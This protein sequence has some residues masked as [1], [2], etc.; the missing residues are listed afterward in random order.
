[1]LTLSH[2]YPLKTREA[3]RSH[4]YPPP[5]MTRSD[6][7]TLSHAYPLKTREA[8]RS[9]MYPPP[10][11]THMYPPPH[12]TRSDMLTL[13]HAYLSRHGLR[14]WSCLGETW[15][16]INKRR[17]STYSLTCVP[18]QDTV[19]DVAHVSAVLTKQLCELL[20]TILSQ[21]TVADVAHVSVV[22]D[23]S[24]AYPVTC[25]PSQDTVSDVAHV[26]VKLE[27][28]LIIGGGVALTWH[29]Q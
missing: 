11:M 8:D 19:S 2:A 3:D 21:D 9:H 10:H 29:C 17:R 26:S 6:M 12:I 22:L 4:M 5:H 23:R 1:M 13:S 27:N 7:L 15:E 18:S 20:W 25:V 24:H 14:R 28:T 16:H